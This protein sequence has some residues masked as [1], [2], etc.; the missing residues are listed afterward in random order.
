MAR[1]LVTGASGFIGTALTP[2]LVAAGHLP[3]LLLR[4][5]PPNAPPA[6]SEV[7]IGDLTEPA[8]LRAALEGCESVVHLGAATSAGALAP[9]LARRVNVDG[10]RALIEACRGQGCSR[11]IVM[12]TQHVHLERPGL[13]G[14]TKR[15]ADALFEGSGLATTRL[16]PSLVY[17]RG[18]R[19]VFVRLA[20][21]VRRL[22]IV[23]IVGPGTWCLRPLYLPDLVRVIVAAL[24]RPDLAGR[25]YDVGGPDLVSFNEFV[26]VICAALGKPFRPVH[27]PLGVSFA[28]AAVFE[29]VLSNPPLTREN[30]RGAT[31]EAPCELGPLLRDLRPS[32]TPLAVGL[33][34]TLASPLA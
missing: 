12:S 22:P 18:T 26:A 14:E 20:G 5:R 2:A 9:A 13:Y 25:S 23:P 1:V 30:V 4:R 8:T 16:R 10:A 11:V 28:L 33:R 24:G 3:R 7:A 34:E 27:L 32:L 31:V 15:A 6:P 29:R 17:G 19:G 21:L